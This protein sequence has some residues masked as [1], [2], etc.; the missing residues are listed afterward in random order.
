MAESRFEVSCYNDY[1]IY[2]KAFTMQYAVRRTYLLGIKVNG[3]NE[4]RDRLMSPDVGV[5]SFFHLLF[6]LVPHTHYE[7]MVDDLRRIVVPALV[8]ERALL[9]CSTLPTFSPLYIRGRCRTPIILLYIACLGNVWEVLCQ[10]DDAVR[11]SE[12]LSSGY[13]DWEAENKYVETVSTLHDSLFMAAVVRCILNNEGYIT[14]MLFAITEYYAQ[15]FRDKHQTFCLISE[16]STL[17]SMQAARLGPLAKFANESMVTIFGDWVNSS[18]IEMEVMGGGTIMLHNHQ[19]YAFALALY[20]LSCDIEGVGGLMWDEGLFSTECGQSSLR[21]TERFLNDITMLRVQ[22]VTALNSLKNT[23]PALPVAR[24]LSTNAVRLSIKKHGFGKAESV[25]VSLPQGASAHFNAYTKNKVVTL[26]ILCPNLKSISCFNEAYTR[27]IATPS[28]RVCTV[29][30]NVSSCESGARPRERPASGRRISASGKSF[31]GGHAI[32]FNFQSPGGFIPKGL[33]PTVDVHIVGYAGQSSEIRRHVYVYSKNPNYET[34][35]VLLTFCRPYANQHILDCANELDWSTVPS[36]TQLLVLANLNQNRLI[37]FEKFIALADRSALSFTVKDGRPKR[38]KFMPRSDMQLIVL[39]TC[40]PYDLFGLWDSRQVKV[41]MN[42]AKIDAINKR[43]SITR[44]DGSALRDKM[45]MEDKVQSNRRFVRHSNKLCTGLGPCTFSLYKI[46]DKTGMG[47]CINTFNFHTSGNYLELHISTAA[48][49]LDMMKSNPGCVYPV[50]IPVRVQHNTCTTV[51]LFGLLNPQSALSHAKMCWDPTSAPMIGPTKTTKFPAYN[52]YVKHHNADKELQLNNLPPVIPLAQAKRRQFDAEDGGSYRCRKSK[53]PRAY[54][55][56]DSQGIV[57]EQQRYTVSQMKQMVKRHVSWELHK[58]SI[59]TSYFQGHALVE[60]LRAVLSW[61]L[62]Q[63]GVA[64][65]DRKQNFMASVESDACALLP[66]SVSFLAE[67]EYIMASTRLPSVRDLFVSRS[68][69]CTYM[70]FSRGN[71]Y[72]P[73][74][75]KSILSNISAQYKLPGIL[76]KYSVN[77]DVLSELRENKN[78]DMGQIGTAVQEYVGK[79]RQRPPICSIRNRGERLLSSLMYGPRP[80]VATFLETVPVLRTLRLNLKR[81]ACEDKN[82]VS[83]LEEK[84]GV[85]QS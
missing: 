20:N 24:P 2:I 67:L 23:P 41:V 63:D 21:N 6:H 82:V 68:M 81:G 13:L 58:N 22:V 10:Q 84:Y 3:N 46:Q 61:Y 28:E 5:I 51:D 14:L 26:Y 25:R 27:Q 76:A 48:I 16:E 32:T 7:F 65:D 40:S 57:C 31:M 36:T 18:M 42:S 69:I 45:L 62:T 39:S 37:A 33:E 43:F 44:L 17:S 83:I 70:G 66:F 50:T 80:F 53:K 85:N 60:R 73:H 59:N 71:G 54:A 34:T 56:F 8:E 64:F 47:S 55:V 38:R 72:M 77:I 12:L 78:M 19:C 74:T 11:I 1:L 52:M 79:K 30:Q 75:S 4:L 29:E 15:L 9:E 49:E 35:S